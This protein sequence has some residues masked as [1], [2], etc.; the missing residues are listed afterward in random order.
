MRTRLV[1]IQEVGGQQSRRET[2]LSNEPLRIGRGAD[3]DLQVPDIRL[4]LAY[5]AVS[6]GG[7]RRSY[8]VE[9]LSPLG[10]RVNGTPVPGATVAP[11]DVI[12]AGRYSLTIAEPDA[13][14]DLVIEIVEHFSAGETKAVQMAGLRTRVSD[15]WLSKRGLSWLLLLLVLLPGLAIPAALR[16][17]APIQTVAVPLPDDRMWLT[18]GGISTAHSFFGNDCSICHVQPFERVRNDVCADCHADIA[19]HANDPLLAAHA[20]FMDVRCASCHLEHNGP[21]GLIVR[22]PRLCVDCHDQPD[23]R[24]AFSELPPSSD[25][26][27]RHPSFTVRLPRHGPDGITL[28][29]VALSA[30]PRE[31]SNLTF[32][33]DIHLDIGGIAAPEGYRV[34]DCASCHEAD[35]GGAHFLPVTMD[36]HCADCHRMDFDPD[37][38]R[39]LLPHADP[40]EIVRIVHDHFAR[41]ALAGGVSDRAAPTVVQAR[42]RAGQAL[43]RSQAEAA[44]RW[45]DARS[46]ETLRDVFERR[47]CVYCHSVSGDAD[48]GWRIDPVTLPQRFMTAARFDHKPH[49][50]EA[51][52]SCHAAAQSAHASDVLMPNVDS[53]RDCHG[54]WRDR[55]VVASTCVDCHGFH[56]ASQP[57]LT[58]LETGQ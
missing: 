37:D 1:H 54:G 34:L 56:T 42:R 29:K 12:D 45:A 16:W 28:Q 13:G 24:F 17:W 10:I 3:Q 41:Q 11:G 18:S 21:R 40:D 7:K 48:S 49:R 33:H 4:P 52:G 50:A 27:R 47:T 6:T 8:R 15:T 44:L 57:L 38:P 26:G 36:A 53:C 43:T 19:H 32:P 2:T 25:F 39:R 51:C 9:A 35:S 30:N 55:G 22:H 58:G 5:A 14:A 46:A 20:D 23:Q 31:T